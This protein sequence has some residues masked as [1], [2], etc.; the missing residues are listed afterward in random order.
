[1]KNYLLIVFFLLF[2]AFPSKSQVI[3]ADSILINTLEQGFW[4]SDFS[5]GINF[6]QASFSGNWR[7]G[8][9]NSIAFGGIVAG[10]ANYMKGKMT[11]DNEVELLYG[12]VNNQGEQ[13]RKQNDRIFMDSKVGY[14][15]TGNWG[16][17]FSANFISQ[18]AP[19]YDYD[20]PE[21]LMISDFLSPGYLTTGL[22][23]EYK[24]NQEFNLRIA[25]LSPRFTFMRN[26]E[27]FLNVPDNYGVPIGSRMRT[28]W[29][30]F[31]LFATWDKDIT[32][33]FNIRSRYMMFANYETLEWQRIDH[34]FDLTLT[35]KITEWVNVTFTSINLYDFDQDPNVQYS[36]ALAI[37]L[38]Y[39]IGNKK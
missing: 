12:I 8:G 11:W 29:L 36:Q 34:R 26:Q 3:P 32:E 38:L 20:T 15:L 31:Q 28:E 27:L 37:G 6:N 10:K 16:A 33:N 24:P 2:A 18:F 39:K 25:P 21:R 23:I 35:A 14:Q 13:S 7:G 19:G 5:V 17:F 9:I 30:A 22:G 4:T 1:M